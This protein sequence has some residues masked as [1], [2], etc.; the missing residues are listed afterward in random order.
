MKIAVGVVLYNPDVKKI[1][2]IIKEYYEK[3]NYFFFVDN[4]LKNINELEKNI[5]NMSDKIII[6]KNTENQGIAKALNQLLKISYEKDINYL[7]TLDQDSFIEYNHI[8][9]MKKY[10]N[11]N[12]AIVC[13]EIIDLN[14]KKNKY[15]KNEYEQVNRCI[16]SGSLMNLNVCRKI[17]Y[18]D[19]KMFIDYVDFD[20]CKRIT[21]KGYKILKIKDC[22]LKHE[23]GKRTIKKFFGVYV[24]P[25]NHSSK[26]VYF[27][28]RNI[29]YYCLKFKNKMTYKEKI[30]EIIRIMWKYIS[31]ILY[32]KDKKEKIKNAN[33]GFLDAKNMF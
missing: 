15:L 19:E 3:V 13:P 23:I 27:Y 33:K 5:R 28:F 30:Y 4:F 21:L 17:G 31:I 7:L 1:K 14:K 22:F 2:L 26:R 32:E 20:Y 12:I 24:Y 8:N 29:H 10:I 6:I 16:T 25:T 18:F 11:D 9:N